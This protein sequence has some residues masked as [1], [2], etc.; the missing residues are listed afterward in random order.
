M[1]ILNMMTSK[2]RG[3]VKQM[4]EQLDALERDLEPTLK[5]VDDLSR[6]NAVL[7]VKL[8]QAEA[9]A[10]VDGGVW[11]GS[12]ELRQAVLVGDQWKRRADEMERELERE[13][14][15]QVSWA[16]DNRWMV[17]RTLDLLA[18]VEELVDAENCGECDE[19]GWN[20]WTC[21]E[22]TC[23]NEAPCENCNRGGLRTSLRDYWEGMRDA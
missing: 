7:Q 8:E 1:A 16:R 22:N 5:L 4:R 19:D 23:D 21:G 2:L 11:H 3:R 13:K 15:R 14:L 6:M 10:L 9:V 12:D 20:R 17:G 18:W